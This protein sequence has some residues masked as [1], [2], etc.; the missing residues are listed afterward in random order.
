MI[1]MAIYLACVWLG[2]CIGV[3]VMALCAMAKDDFF[4]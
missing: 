3:V 1:D 2:A 4:E